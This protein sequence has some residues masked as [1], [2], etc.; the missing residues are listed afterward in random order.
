M[1]STDSPFMGVCGS[2]ALK[3]PHHVV[4]DGPLD[5]CAS[6]PGNPVGVGPWCSLRVME[7]PRVHPNLL[8]GF[9]GPGPAGETGTP[10]TI[11]TSD[12]QIRNLL[13]YPLSYGGVRRRLTHF[14]R[15][16]D[17]EDGMG[18]SHGGAALLR[19]RRCSLC[20]PWQIGGLAWGA[21]NG[22]APDNFA[23][24]GGWWLGTMASVR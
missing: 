8:A 23:G 24:P 7:L 17:P 21:A 14:E 2:S 3:I 12:L 4:T 5:R 22:E 18:R 19:P 16:A 1:P 15:P 9:V 11:R 20:A 6:G 13:L 10:E